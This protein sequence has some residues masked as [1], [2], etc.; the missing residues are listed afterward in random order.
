MDTVSIVGRLSL[1]RR[2]W[3]WEGGKCTRTYMPRKC[4][5]SSTDAHQQLQGCLSVCVC[6]CVCVLCSHLRCGK[7]HA[8]SSH[9]VEVLLD[10]PSQVDLTALQ[11]EG[12]GRGGRRVGRGNVKYKEGRRKY[13]TRYMY[14]HRSG[15]KPC[16]KIHVYT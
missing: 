6:V 13:A 7:G 10:L 15:V 3:C 11:V 8:N 16:N 1:S 14:I 9:H 5:A 4:I 2:L 12:R